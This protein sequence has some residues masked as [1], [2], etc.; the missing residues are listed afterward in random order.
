MSIAAVSGQSPALNL[1]L[2]TGQQSSQPP[3]RAVTST[4]APSQGG[5]AVVELSA[6]AQAILKG[7]KN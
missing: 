3:A 4:P 1:N 2:Q 7:S 6:E 5:A